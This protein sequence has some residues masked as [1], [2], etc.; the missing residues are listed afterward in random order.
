[1][2]SLQC[3]PEEL[4]HFIHNRIDRCLKNLPKLSGSK[5][6]STAYPVKVTCDSAVELGLGNKFKP[7]KYAYS[8][9]LKHISHCAIIPESIMHV[10]QIK[11]NK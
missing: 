5:I 9:Q 11:T 3:A 8:K 2:V 4:I 6:K 10:D 1:M 7:R